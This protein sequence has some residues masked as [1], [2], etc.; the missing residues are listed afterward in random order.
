MFAE[1]KLLNFQLTSLITR[2]KQVYKLTI[3]GY[4]VLYDI[5]MKRQ[6]DEKTKR[7]KDGKIKWVKDK[8]STIQKDRR[9]E[10]QKNRKM[11]RQKDRKTF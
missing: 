4:R 3:S 11:E 10:R 2:N 8:K 9:M 5:E 1:T 6:K 7:Q